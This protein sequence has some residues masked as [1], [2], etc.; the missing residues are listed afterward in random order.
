MNRDPVTY[1]VYVII[2]L[3][4]PYLLLSTHCTS[5]CCWKSLDASSVTHIISCYYV[6]YVYTSDCVISKRSSSIQPQ[7]WGFDKKMIS[8]FISS[9]LFLFDSHGV[10]CSSFSALFVSFYLHGERVPGAINTSVV[11]WSFITL[12][13]SL[14][15][16]DGTQNLYRSVCLC[17]LLLRSGK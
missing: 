17:I 7:Q 12:C 3:H 14:F 4:R 11:C 13:P 10:S 6:M 9:I 5:C 2:Y 8:L 16:D 1:V 15:I